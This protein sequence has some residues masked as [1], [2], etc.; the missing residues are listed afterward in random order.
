M[1]VTKAAALVARNSVSASFHLPC[2]ILG[3]FN[4]CSR[5]KRMQR[6]TNGTD[7]RS[8]FSDSM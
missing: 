8:P 5:P 2:K 3:S 1:A 6:S 7:T 4:P